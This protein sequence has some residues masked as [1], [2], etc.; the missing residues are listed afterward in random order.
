[1]SDNF[2]QMELADETW[3]HGRASTNRRKIVNDNTISWRARRG[4]QAIVLYMEVNL[5]GPYLQTTQYYTI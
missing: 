1:M 5:I 4:M 3:Q 2:S